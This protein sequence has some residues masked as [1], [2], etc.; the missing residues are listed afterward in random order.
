M[1]QDAKLLLRRAEAAWELKRPLYGILTECWRYAAPGVDPYRDGGGRGERGNMRRHN[2][3]EGRYSHLYDATLARSATKHANRLISENFPPGRHWAELRSGPLFGGSRDERA[4]DPHA[5]AMH[6]IRERIFEA[7]HA[8]NFALASNAMALDAVISGT[9]CMKVGVSADSSTLLDF[10]A[11]NQSEVA[12]EA[13]PRGTVWGFYRRMSETRERIQVLW[14]DASLPEEAGDDWQVGQ[15]KD[16]DLMECTVYDPQA[17]LW[18]YSVVLDGGSDAASVVSS[19]DY[20][21]CPWVVWRYMLLAG[22]VQG[23]SPVMAALPDARTANHAVRVRLQS[24]SL[25]VNGMFTFTGNDVFNPA[26]VELRSGAFLPVGSNDNQNP[27]IRPLELPGDPQ[28]GELVLE[29]TRNSIRETMLDVGLPE[30]TGSVR[31][32]TEIIERQRENMQQFGMPYL[33][34][35]EEVGR[36]ILRAVAYLLAEAG[37][38]E[39]LAELQPAGPDGRPMPL[40]LDGRDVAVQ[41]TSPLVTAQRLSDAETVVRWAE[42]ARFV[43]GEDGY[44]A[45][46]KTAFAPGF[47]AEKMGVDGVMLRDEE[48]RDAAEDDLFE[49]RVGAA[50]AQGETTGQNLPEP[51]IV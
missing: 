35:I 29:D 8:S 49:A 45:S 3:G 39:E 21:V 14:P 43:A 16:Y 4:E 18:R 41:F 24:A 1:P 48:E 20:V 50:G 15:P 19:R 27:T 38:L 51:E 10:E 22:E 23:R 33:R 6:A 47:L 34:L 26:V 2:T 7:I 37:Q 30:P 25:R 12:F 46:V 5:E 9:G 40:M 28:F 11:V 31:S 44:L 32:A 17:G 42:M 13:G 36:P